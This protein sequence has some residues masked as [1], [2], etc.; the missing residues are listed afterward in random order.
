MQKG[1][2]QTDLI[3]STLNRS[4]LQFQIENE[5]FHVIMIEVRIPMHYF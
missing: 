5:P 2:T 3:S 4:Q 1:Q